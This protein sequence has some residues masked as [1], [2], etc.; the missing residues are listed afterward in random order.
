ML[1][2]ELLC[3]PVKCEIQ[4]ERFCASE[5]ER[6]KREQEEFEQELA[7]QR[8]Q[9]DMAKNQRRRQER[10]RKED[11]TDEETKVADT[12]ESDES[13]TCYPS[14]ELTVLRPPVIIPADDVDIHT[15][16]HVD[17]CFASLNEEVNYQKKY[18]DVTTEL[19]TLRKKKSVEQFLSFL[20]PIS[21]NT[22]SFY[23]KTFRLMSKSLAKAHI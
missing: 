10:E 22:M 2:E 4:L 23:P 18:D 17:S 15:E 3:L 20:V 19:V 11:F 6:F 14:D 7:E 13:L 9:R 21:T 8:K 5:Q 16:D 1:I 12:S